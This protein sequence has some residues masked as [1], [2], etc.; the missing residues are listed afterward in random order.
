[1]IFQQQSNGETIGKYVGFI[2]GFFVFTTVLF[3]LLTF[4]GKLTDS[5][6]YVYVA[7]IVL[8]ISLVGWG[9]RRFFR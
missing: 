9:I 6:S 1:M 3:L 2:L 8:A 5:W 4:L 7:G